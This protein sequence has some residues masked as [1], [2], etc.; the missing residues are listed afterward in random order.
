[1]YY[2]YDRQVPKQMRHATSNNALVRSPGSLSCRNPSSWLQLCVIVGEN[3]LARGA[4]T[5]RDMTTSQ[6]R[7]VP[8]AASGL[9]R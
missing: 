5:L 1:M 3:E 6:Q 9:L 4:V 7:E 2:S 8:R